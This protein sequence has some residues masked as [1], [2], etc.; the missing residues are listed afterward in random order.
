MPE[1]TYL[2]DPTPDQIEQI[3]GLYRMEG[4]WTIEPYDPDHV[5]RIVAGSH[6]FVI[7][8]IADEIVGM[9]RAISDGASDAY[10]QDITAKKGY[11]GQKIGSGIVKALVSRLAEDGIEWIGLI[12]ERGSHNFYRQFGFKKMP[13]SVPMLKITT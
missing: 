1:F 6:C 3:I 13:D 8:T 9:G 12:A 2:V 11:R 5:I 10:L 4:W 7:A